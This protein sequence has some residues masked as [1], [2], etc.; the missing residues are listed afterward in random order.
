M[1]AAATAGVATPASSGP[2]L[3]SNAPITGSLAALFVPLVAKDASGTYCPGT[4]APPITVAELE[5]AVFEELSPG[6]VTVGST[7]NSCTQ[8]RLRLTQDNSR[9]VEPVVLPCNGTT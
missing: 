5:A 9:V 1:A 8:G 4:G 3:S 2:R 7:Y 6:E